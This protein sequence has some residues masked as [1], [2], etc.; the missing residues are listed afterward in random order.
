MLLKS[1]QFGD[2]THTPA[3]QMERDYGV[4]NDGGQLQYLGLL[5]ATGLECG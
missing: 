2:Y 1:R 5:A 3:F 4:A